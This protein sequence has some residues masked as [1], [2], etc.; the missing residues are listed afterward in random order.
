MSA[1]PGNQF[2]LPQLP[3]DFGGNCGCVLV[4][5]LGVLLLML[6]AAG[7]A[8]P[9]LS[10]AGIQIPGL[11]APAPA[12]NTG[13]GGGAGTSASPGTGSPQATATAS[14]AAAPASV[15][16]SAPTGTLPSAP[17]SPAGT[18]TVPGGGG[19]AV[20]PIS[21]RF[22]VGG[23]VHAVTRGALASEVDL[24]IDEIKSYVSNDGLAW[25]AFGAQG[26]P[27]EVLITFNEPENTV[28]VA[29][30]SRWVKGV[31]DECAFDVDV[32]EALVSGHISCATAE[33][34]EGDQLVGE[35]SIEVDFTAAS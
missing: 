31:D 4:V 6:L 20:P 19:S 35:A 34:Y 2:G 33:V 30:G 7:L 1:S 14:S 8:G 32:T 27:D 9:L 23:S 18:S 11:N 5:V 15:A 22:F 24:P 17:A 21:E 26:G 12:A 3:D 29:Q 13:G 25:I 28:T 16:A 10:G